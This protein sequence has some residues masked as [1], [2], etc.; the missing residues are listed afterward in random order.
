MLLFAA[1]LLASPAQLTVTPIAL[2]P[3]TGPV[4]MDYLATSDHGARIWVPAGNTGKVDVIDAASGK[5]TAIDGFETAQR[6]GRLVGPSSASAGHGVVYVGNR[7]NYNV[8]AIVEKSLAK[9]GCMVLP[10]SP[11]GVAWVAATKE[12]WVTTPRD[13]SLTLLNAANPGSLQYAARIA[14][15]GEP[16]G[17]A[18][19]DAKGFFY[20]NLEDKDR[21][22]VLDVKTRKIVATWNPG[23]GENGPRGLAIDSARG[24]LYV[25]CTDKVK[26]LSTR[27][28]SVLGEVL[29]GAGIDNIDYRK[30][31][32]TIY[33][34]S[35]KTGTLTLATADDKG[36]LSVSAT[37]QTAKGARV[38][39][40]GLRGA[41][42]VADSQGGRILM[43]K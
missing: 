37:A 9:T 33:I 31:T 43:V 15:P 11:D 24:Q 36:R 7:A 40:A 2:P 22:L 23:C 41:A 35:G 14:L 28:G 12:V 18:V 10:S 20:T 6:Q 25:A 39:V 34:A 4:V 13:Q 3:G 32:K 42:Y 21:T 17:Y 16:E 19:D 38:V 5:V 26:T 29:A 8:C 30:A 27:D 1:L